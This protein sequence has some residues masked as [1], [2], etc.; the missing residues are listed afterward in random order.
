MLHQ[1]ASEGVTGVVLTPH[2][3]ASEIGSGGEEQ[4]ELRERAFER[5]KA[6]APERPVLHLGFEILLDQPLPAHVF[7]DRRYSLAGSKYYLVEFPPVVEAGYAT[8][9]LLQFQAAGVVPVVAHPERYEAGIPST[10]RTWRQAGARAQV[11][12]TAITRPGRRGERARR[13]LAE[14]L[15]DVIA[16]DNHGDRRSL[17]AGVEYLTRRHQEDAAQML[18]VFNP[19][20]IVA[21]RAL[22]EPSPVRLRGALWDRV[23][24][25]FSD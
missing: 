19:G 14:G 10:L 25:I 6:A 21:D 13:L 24:Q 16:A 18:A 17:R 23:R 12:A 4:L 9:A 8:H 5:L 11:D 7:G 1:F 22:S 3:W 20:A 15:A 2:L